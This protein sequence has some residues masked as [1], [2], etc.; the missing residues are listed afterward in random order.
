ME[1][2][3]EGS[4]AVSVGMRREHRDPPELDPHT[5]T[6]PWGEPVQSRV[7][8]LALFCP[9]SGCFWNSVSWADTWQSLRQSSNNNLPQV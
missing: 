1:M 7:P 2:Q 8:K 4:A 5:G 6:C 9:F 3:S